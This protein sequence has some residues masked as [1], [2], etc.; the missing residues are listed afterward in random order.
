[1]V[2]DAYRRLFVGWVMADQLRT[3]RVLAAVA[4]DMR[5]R[6]PA[7]RLVHPSDRGPNAPPRP[8]AFGRRLREAGFVA[9]M[10][11]FGDPCETAVAESFFA[12]LEAERRCRRPWPVRAAARSASFE[13][14][15]G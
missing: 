11:S 1:V 5:S 6:R 3:E 13:Y 14:M 7:P 8:S 9:S 12:T 2:L 10:G 15:E 4:M